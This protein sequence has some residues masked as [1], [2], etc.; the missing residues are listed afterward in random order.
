MKN[1]LDNWLHPYIRDPETLNLWACLLVIFILFECIGFL[2]T[3]VFLSLVIA[4]LL[5]WPVVFLQ[6]LYFSRI[7]AVWVVYSV[8]MG[9][10]IGLYV[11]VMPLIVQQLHNLLAELPQV[12][13]HTQA[14]LNYLHNHY[15][16]YLSL[17]QI[18]GITLEVKQ[19]MHYLAHWILSTLLISIPDL[20]AL[21]IYIVLVPLLIYFFLMDHKEILNWVAEFLPEHRRLIVEV[22]TE[23]YTKTGHYARGKAIEIIIVWIITA[24]VF[25]WMRLPYSM[26]LGFMTGLS[27]VIPY[28]GTV[29]VTVPVVLVGFMEWGWS[30]QLVYMLTAYT[31]INVLDSHLL[32]PF[33]FAEAMSLHPVAIMV[34]TLVF[35]GLFGFW[36]VFLC[37]PLAVLTNSVLN[38]IKR[39]QTHNTISLE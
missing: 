28:I 4:Y 36:G 37:I 6:R 17:E 16:G 39:F 34:S 14:L 13:T 27:V 32:F 38:I 15:P 24:L 7:A 9:C 3:P 25:S 2:L 11:L 31:V 23:V 26:L 18:Q 1:A 10:I 22:W 29:I 19:W 33:L 21:S 35:G 12:T 20:I 30:Q 8:F 5:H